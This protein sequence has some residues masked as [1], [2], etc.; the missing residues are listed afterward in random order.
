MVRQ[1]AVAKAAEFLSKE[2][3]KYP[4]TKG[5][6]ISG[7][8]AEEIARQ[9]ARNP[10]AFK[11]GMRLQKA[12]WAKPI[13]SMVDKTVSAMDASKPAVDYITKPRLEGTM[14]AIKSRIPQ[15]GPSLSDRNIQGDITRDQAQDIHTALRSGKEWTPSEL[16]DLWKDES[17]TI[18]RKT[19]PSGYATDS[20]GEKFRRT[21]HGTEKPMQVPLKLYP[22]YR[23]A[24]DEY[25]DAFD[26]ATDS[27]QRKALNEAWN[28][29]PAN[30]AVGATTDKAER[31]NSTFGRKV[32]QATR[33]A[34]NLAEAKEVLEGNTPRKAI[35]DA[36]DAHS[37]AS[38]KAE[39]VAQ[40]FGYDSKQ[41]TAASDAASESFKEL[42]R[43][44]KIADT[45]QRGHMKSIADAK[46]ERRAANASAKIQAKERQPLD[47]T[48]RAASEAEA[49]RILQGE[50]R[51]AENE[52]RKV[53]HPEPT[54][55]PISALRP[56]LTRLRSLKAQLAE[57]ESEPKSKAAN[58]LLDAAEEKTPVP[59]VKSLR[60]QIQRLQQAMSR[61]R[62]P[63]KP[64]APGFGRTK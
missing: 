27:E 43:V 35:A 37:I 50:Q 64:Q 52:A 39:Q 5:Y 10:K 49:G 19:D 25:S 44:E 24:Y 58:E 47:L 54:M 41:Y 32:Q 42:Q 12:G 59:N 56:A 9:I 20:G 62:S 4:D 61:L 18:G 16:A 40:K 38:Q 30:T 53:Q 26:K 21:Q 29:H 63:E 13:S 3:D 36:Q 7:A 14:S 1:K 48:T 34:R 2:F 51:D 23:T 6:K 60:T 8:E 17:G 22:A 45:V 28:K 15:M 33:D 31:Q 11:T 55:T 57:A 46:A